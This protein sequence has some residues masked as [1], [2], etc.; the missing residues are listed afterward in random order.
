MKTEA[1][2]IEIDLLRIIQVLWINVWII[3]L[4]TL[5]FGGG[6][7]AFTYFCITPQYQA[8]TKMYVNNSSFSVGNSSFSIT[9]QELSA[10]QSLVST[11][12]VIL[13]SRST[14]NQVIELASLNYTTAQLSEMISASAIN[15]TEVFQVTVT[16]P[17]PYEAEMIAN[18]IVKVL[19]QQISQIVQGSDV[20]VIDHAIIPVR[21]SSPSYSRNA[22]LCAFCGGCFAVF[23]IVLYDLLDTRIHSEEDLKKYYDIPILSV[24]PDM[25]VHKGS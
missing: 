5:L 10:A 19:P 14:L 12:I 25:T 6:G 17:N 4:S 24:V 23:S 8:D 1:D 20:R 13:K 16:S 9:S 21:R 22:V 2:E 11:Y 3:I 18:T 7:I 15:S